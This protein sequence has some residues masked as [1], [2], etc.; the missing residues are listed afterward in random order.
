MLA[1]SATRDDFETCPMPVQR[2]T[3]SVDGRYSAE[4]MGRI[5]VGLIP[6]SMDD[7]WFIFL[8]DDHLYMHRSWTGFCIFDVELQREGNDWV[9]A[10]VE[11][12]RDSEQYGSTDPVEDV[13]RLS[14]LID[15]LLQGTW[16]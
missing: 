4:E 11:V 7:R 9:I 14:R 1:K 5:K 2:A 6:E 10:R 16:G 3:L 13:G 15:R 8:E 12:N